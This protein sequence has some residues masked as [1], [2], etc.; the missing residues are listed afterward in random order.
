[1]IVPAGVSQNCG[2]LPSST[3]SVWT[4]DDDAVVQSPLLL[5]PVKDN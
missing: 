4:A 3:V 2:P 1:M 5:V